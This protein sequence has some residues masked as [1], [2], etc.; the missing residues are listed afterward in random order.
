MSLTLPLNLWVL[1]ATDEEDIHE[2]SGARMLSLFKSPAV[3]LICLVVTVS[4]S[5]WSVLEPTLVIHMQ[6]VGKFIVILVCSPLIGS[7][8]T[9]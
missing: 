7:C 1:P 4:S 8:C 5:A 6:Q 9:V 2:K 3:V